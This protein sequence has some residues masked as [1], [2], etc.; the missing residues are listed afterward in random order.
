MHKKK[1]AF[2]F[3]GVFVA[4]ALVVCMFMERNAFSFGKASAGEIDTSDATKINPLSDERQVSGSKLVL[5]TK[6]LEVHMVP[7]TWELKM[8]VPGKPFQT[9]SQAQ[10][11]VNIQHMRK[12]SSSASWEVPAKGLKILVQVVKKSVKVKVEANKETAVTWPVLGNK[13]ENKAMILPLAEG[14]YVPTRDKDWIQY[15]TERGE[16]SLNEAFSMPFWGVQGNGCTLT[17]RVD[18]PFN[19]SVTFGNDHEH[20]RL[21]VKHDFTKKTIH[22]AYGVAI[23][24]GK[25]D[26]NEPAKVFR[27]T[28]VDRSQFVSLHAKIRKNPSVRKLLGAAHV[29][30]WG[31]GHLSPDDIKDWGKFA[32]R[33][34]GQAQANGPSP[35]KR[36][37]QLLDS[38]GR[39]TLT[40]IASQN[41]ADK[42]QKETVARS[43]DA[44]LSNRGFY[45]EE[46]WKNTHLAQKTKTLLSKPISSLNESSVYQLNDWLLHD[47]FPE[48]LTPVSSW[49][50]GVSTKILKQFHSAGLD[51]L[52]LG[53]A[54]WE[55]AYKHP[56]FV[57]LAQSMG[58]LAATYDS[59]NTVLNPKN[60]EDPSFKTAIFD[61]WL[62]DHGAIVRADG[63]KVPGFQ[64]KGYT[65]SPLVTAPYVEKRHS[66][67]M[68]NVN[69]NSWFVDA[70]GDGQLHE[71]YSAEHPATQKDDM[72][73]KIKRLN[74]FAD[75]RLVVGTE[76]GV[77]Y[78]APAV[79]FAH[80]MTTPALGGWV[81]KDMGDKSSK[82]YLGGYWPPEG[83]DVFMKPVPIKPKY[84]RVFIDPRFQ[85]PLYEL[86]F[87]DS[88]ITTHHWGMGS[89]KLR[90][91]TKTRA[92]TEML[93]DVPPLYHLNLNAWNQDKAIIKKHYRFFSP[94][95][96][97][98]SL[99]EMTRFDW[100]TPDR[101]I[102]KTVYGGKLEIVANYSPKPFQYKK[103]NI[104]VESV[105]I[106][107]LK[108]G[109]TQ[110]YTP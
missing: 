2:I 10:A 70:D 75:H 88:V 25:G 107:W 35:G 24:W 7:S 84:H 91:E 38:E 79:A 81:D 57:K 56:Q 4:M 44:V 101:S 74:W 32:K 100:L 51:R 102:Q 54:D 12:G 40:K 30:I 67:I 96:K 66:S 36:V 62:Y 34:V 6:E 31:S 22:Q 77:W 29:Y 41:D 19:D 105:W 33:I 110:V 61:Q 97:Q 53:V 43:L 48:V 50:D 78:T 46:A 15:L 49:G 87:H 90:D 52:W 63:M 42:F 92:L 65:A 47:A 9:I 23:Y 17:Y 37:W 55:L 89:L 86:V 21:S 71:D 72:N 45:Q 85:F 93:Y 82:Y 83:P 13:A 73:A 39:N 104:P 76:N 1:M 109:K 69:L 80:G 16:S 106:H 98:A 103:Q 99:L 68:K 94:V 27:Q 59:Y 18:N 20:L 26:L 108:N 28:L 5:K 60:P 95:H 14:R 58:Y 3:I 64:R 11:A 8:R